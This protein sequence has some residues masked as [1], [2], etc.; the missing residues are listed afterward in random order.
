MSN[1]TLHATFYSADGMTTGSP[2]GGIFH[3]APSAKS[4]STR[5]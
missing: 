5:R 3:Q 1:S 2:D 4:C